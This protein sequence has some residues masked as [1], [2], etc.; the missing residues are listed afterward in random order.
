MP[1][2]SSDVEATSRNKAA[3]FSDKPLIVLR[4]AN[5]MPGYED[6]QKALLSLSTNS[7]AVVA[8]NSGHYIM[9]DRPDLVI[10]AIR[11]VVEAAQ[12]H[13]KLNH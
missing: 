13:T 6:L 2:C 7:K 12:H 3:P 8:E 10:T 4:T 11:K 9:V 5:S 1:E